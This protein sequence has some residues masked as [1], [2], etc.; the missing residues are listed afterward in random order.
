[1]DQS[2]SFKI[3]LVNSNLDLEVTEQQSIYTAAL[4]VGLQL[5]VGC[6]YGGATFICKRRFRR[7]AEKR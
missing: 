7:L 6:Q 1:M 4:A 3:R 2:N 5:P